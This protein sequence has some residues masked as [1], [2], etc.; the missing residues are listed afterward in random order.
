M[1]RYRFNIEGLHCANCASKIERA[2]RKEDGIAYASLDFT[3]M[4]LTVRSDMDEGEVLSIIQPIADRIEPGTVFVPEGSDLEEGSHRW[5]IIR[6]ASCTVVFL[7][8]FL[9]EMFGDVDHGVLSIVFLAVFVAAGAETIVDALRGILRGDV[10]GESF[11]MSVATI[12]AVIIGQYAEAAAVMVLF[13]IGELIEDYAVGSSRRRIS[14]FSDMTPKLVHLEKDGT[15]TDV[16]PND[17]RVGDIIVIRPGERVPLDGTVIDGTTELDTSALTG[18]S[19][20][21]SVTS[22]YQV[23]SGSL[24]TTGT[25]RIEVTKDYEDSTL[26]HIMEL[27]ESAGERKAQSERFITRFARAYTPTVCALALLVAVIP[28]ALGMDA[29]TWIYRA[30]TFLVLSCPCALVISVPMTIMSGIGC[31]SSNGI[32]VKGGNYLE[33][34]SQIDTMAFDKTGTITNGRFS[35][36]GTE[37]FDDDLLARTIVSLESHSNHPIAKAICGHF[38]QYDSVVNDIREIPGKGMEGVVDGTKAYAGNAS[39]MRDL[40]HRVDDPEGRTSVHVVL[41]D[42]YL[43]HVELMD[44]PK[45]EARRT[46]EEVRALGVRKVTMLT[47]DKDSV[48][49]RISEDLSLDAYVADM[50]PQDKLTAI[51]SLISDANG[52]TAFVGDGINDGPTLRRADLGISM[53]QMGSDTAMEASDII[54]AGGDLSRIPLAMRISRRTMRILKQNIVLSLGIKVGILVLT[55]LGL[56]EMWGAVIG[57]VGACMLAI[58][59]SLRALRV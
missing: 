27:M 25:I 3:R 52:V 42:R 1:M 46:V 53:G 16:A 9:I 44:I 8:A 38:P 31:A 26:S 50:L 29:E 30:L 23:L 34:L 2:I 4:V 28:I 7:I 21:V 17:V 51:E 6:T 32:L 41:G 13:S 33:M 5:E 47:G 36:V 40:G 48:A 22:E 11:L 19:V 12:G 56:S 18:E 43:G 55:L 15:V 39:F 20:P 57:D 49:R 35:V 24:N 54:I 45:D 37:S 14:A 10:F 58:L 59:N